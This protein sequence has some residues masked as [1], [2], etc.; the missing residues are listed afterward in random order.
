MIKQDDIPKVHSLISRVGEC[1]L[2][3]P[4]DQKQSGQH[5]QHFRHEALID[6]K[7]KAVGLK[8]QLRISEEFDKHFQEIAVLTFLIDGLQKKKKDA[9]SSNLHC[10]PHVQL[11]RLLLEG[12]QEKKVIAMV[13]KPK[14]LNRHPRLTCHLPMTS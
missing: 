14:P 13:R 10:I 7:K 1:L 5:H 2:P 9:T 6:T 8:T 3:C 12:R 11:F 4:E